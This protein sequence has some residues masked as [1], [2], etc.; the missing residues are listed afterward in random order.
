MGKEI[1]MRKIT[2]IILVA[3]LLIPCVVNGEEIKAYGGN[4][5]FYST[6]RRISFTDMAYK[7]VDHWSKDAVYTVAALSIMNGSDGN[8]NSDDNLTRAE[9]LAM[10][11]RAAGLEKTAN[12]YS[13][14]VKKK[15]LEQPNKYNNICDWADGYLRL[16]VDYKIISVEDYTAEMEADY[17]KAVFK[18]DEPATKGEVALWM[19]A[20][21]GLEVATKENYVT[22]FDDALNAPYISRLYYET[23]IKNGILKGDG[24]NLGVLKYITRE[25]AAQMF[26]NSI[27]LF[28]EKLGI[29]VFTDTVLSN[30]LTSVNEPDKIHNKRVVKLEKSTL[31]ATRTYDLNGEAVD[32][33]Y[34]P[35]NE[36]KDM[37]VIKHNSLPQGLEA[38]SQGDIVD[39]YTKNGEVVLINCLQKKVQTEIRNEEDY[40]DSDV[41]IGKLY[42][43]D[44]EEKMVVIKDKENKLIEIPYLGD[45]LLCNREKELTVDE[46]N[47]LWTDKDV[48]VFTI[49]KKN[50][51]VSR[52]YRIQLVDKGE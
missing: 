2:A 40:K 23:A 15:K 4:D 48:Y 29:E 12:L 31:Q 49:I 17:S 36:Y 24:K 42:Y 14:T 1:K 20:V 38:L 3:L 22:E 41:Y 47:S 45:V 32:L 33:N 7:P 34:N 30:T 21:F 9:A 13:E 43:V 28:K 11:F 25:E 44:G 52:A 26:Y 8:F 37:V 35:E 18:K 16:A 10:I 51:T 5:G 50:G 39:V 6:I 19:V 46:A 27:K